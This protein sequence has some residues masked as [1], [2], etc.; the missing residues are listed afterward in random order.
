MS[1]RI[2]Y[3]FKSLA[4]IFKRDGPFS[5]SIESYH[6]ALDAVRLHDGVPVPIQQLFETA[7]NISLYAFYAY[8]L[9]QPAELV[10]YSAFEMA[11]RERAKAEHPELFKKK[12]TPMFKDFC[13]LAIQENWFQ[14]EGFSHLQ[15]Q[16]Y[17]HAKW[18]K[19]KALIEHMTAEGLTEAEVEEPTD[20]DVMQALKELTDF[21]SPLLESFRQLRNNLAHGSSMLM[22]SS[23]RTLGVLAEAINQIFQIPQ[24][25]SIL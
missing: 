9:N 20:E 10:G 12:K 19:D 25:T 7:K 16:A 6:A 21:A 2:D 5:G 17:R 18:T 15:R 11:L 4:N 3:P 13:D 23:V 14:P 22:P 24:K 8:R 1:N